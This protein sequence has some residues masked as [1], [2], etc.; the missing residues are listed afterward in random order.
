MSGAASWFVETARSGLESLTAER[1]LIEPCTACFVACHTR[2][3][4]HI[5][6]KSNVSTRW[7]NAAAVTVER[8]PNAI[9]EDSAS[10]DRMMT[11]LMNSFPPS[12]QGQVSL[13]NWRTAP[14]NRWAFQHVREI[15]PSADIANDP[16]NVRPLP[17][18][19]MDIDGLR[20]PDPAG[21]A[22]TLDAFLQRASTDALVVLRDGRMVI[23]RYANGMGPRIPH[24]LMSVSKSLLGL[25]T[26]TLVRQGQ[27]DTEALVTTMVPEL[28]GTAY[29][30]ATVR[31][32]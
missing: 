3:F 17:A 15:V 19:T 13:A 28:I 18:A 27:V 5:G 31:T 2:R 32:P 11:D 4:R 23:E 1:D 25:V 26:G 12:P 24:I 8:E 30:G 21:P 29:E 20:I 9:L 6:P 22:L 10:L 7:S 16:S 14:F